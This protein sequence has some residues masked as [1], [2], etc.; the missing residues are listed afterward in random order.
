MFAILVCPHAHSPSPRKANH[1]YP[2]TPVSVPVKISWIAIL[3][4]FFVCYRL[5]HRDVDPA[6]DSSSGEAVRST[7]SSESETESRPQ[8]TNYLSNTE[9]SKDQPQKEDITKVIKI[10]ADA[11]SDSSCNRVKND[12]SSQSTSQDIVTGDSSGRLVGERRGST[13]RSPEKGIIFM[14]VDI[15]HKGQPWSIAF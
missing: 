7:K 15:F 11:S 12:K 3:A 5:I 4:S 8:V 6:V 9:P 1:P 13:E 2:C 14:F 10:V